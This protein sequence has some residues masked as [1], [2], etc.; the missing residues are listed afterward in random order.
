MVLFG[1]LWT[2]NNNR[3]YHTDDDDLCSVAS[4]TTS[5]AGAGDLARPDEEQPSLTADFDADNT[6]NVL[7]LC[8]FYL[9]SY[10][11]VAVVAYSYVFEKWTIID[12][13]YFAVSTFT[14]VG[15]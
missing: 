8:T 15:K 11:G 5:S 12:S 13:V 6:S 14:T 9:T 2:S 4:N 3:S 10:I 7:K 1:G